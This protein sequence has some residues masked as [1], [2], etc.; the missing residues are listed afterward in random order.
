MLFTGYNDPMIDAAIALP[1]FGDDVKVPFDKFGWFYTRNGSA[2]LTGVF[3]VNTGT[4]K[5]SEL[6]QMNSWNYK[7]HTGFFESYCGMTNGSAGEFQPPQLQPGGSVGL[8]TPDMCRTLRLDYEETVEIEGLQGY[9]FTGGLR[10]VDN[11][12]EYFKL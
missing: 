7:N 12:K 6:G 1:I 10:S 8:F 4:E 2:D 11:G 9:K 3:N 5:L